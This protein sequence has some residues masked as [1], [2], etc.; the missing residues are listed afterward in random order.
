MGDLSI[1]LKI[2]DREYPMKV[3]A[4]DEERIRRAGKLINEKLRKYRERFRIDDK[5]DLLA[6]VAFECMADKLRIEEQSSHLDEAIHEK[7]HE[8]NQL[9]T[10][11][12]WHNPLHQ[13][14]Y[15]R[16]NSIAHLHIFIFWAGKAGITLFNHKHK[17]VLLTW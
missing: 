11:S 6:M 8:L 2:G 9:I 13:H 4:E 16:C 17:R 3:K 14:I 10:K 1:K 5:Q 12:I 15:T 7:I